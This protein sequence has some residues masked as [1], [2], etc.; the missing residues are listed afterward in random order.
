[1][2]YRYQ[3]DIHMS[4][5]HTEALWRD[6]PRT[7][8]E[9]EE[10]FASE[11]ACRDY[12]AVCRWNGRPRCVRCDN[13]RVW[14][15]RDG[16]LYECAACGH[17][18][19]LT[20]GTLFHGTRKPLRLWFRAI[21][22]ICVH[23]HGISAADLQR[24]LGL[25]SYQTAWTWAHRIRRAMVRAKRER[26][27]GT[28]QMDET[29]VG[30]KAADKAMVLAAVEEGGRVRLVHIPGN[31]AP[32]IGHVV[33]DEIDGDAAIKTDGHAAY[34]ATTL[35][36]RSHEAKVQTAEERQTDDHVQLCHRAASGLKRWLLGTHHGAV[37][38]KHLQSY[39]DEHAFRYNRRKTKGVGRLVAR[40]LENMIAMKPVTMRQLIH[41]THPHRTFDCVNY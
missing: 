13:E 31:H 19:S 33:D 23:R 3:G 36:A 4:E 35:G 41:D 8:L 17:Q 11:E 37:R 2:L 32:C 5:M 28:V 27:R 29:Y 15:E 14:P 38:E 16:A 24:I 12:L 20:S 1:M 34:N 25:G 26:L 40:C 39:L 6:F 21:W 22:E 9:F 10:R 7:L 18:T 30:G